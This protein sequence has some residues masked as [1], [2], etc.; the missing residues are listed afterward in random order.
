MFGM[1]LRSKTLKWLSVPNAGLDTPV[2]TTVLERGVRLTNAHVTDIPI[3]EYVLRAVLDH[4]QHAEQWRDAQRRHAWD[5]HQFREVAG[6]TWLIVGLGTIGQA[7]ATRARAFG[8]R[9]VGCRRSP[10]GHESVDLMV[11]PA[12]VLTTL[13]AADV[14]VLSLPSTAETPPL[15]D[16]EFLHAMA[17]G[18]VLVN[19]ARGSLIDEA[20]LLAALD[21]GRP[22]AA[23]LDVMATEPLPDDSPLWV[24][25]RVVLTPH[26]SAGG[27]DRYHRYDDL[28][29]D[30]L[31]RY[32]RGEP[33]RNEVSIP[34]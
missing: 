12:D 19:I 5:R 6:T 4:F 27:F 13:P 3:S 14:V 20:A 1:V 31:G 29:V 28:L 22:A 15:V 25:P 7:V 17:E 10:T 24:H 8:A 18:S 16:A 9:V 34:G 21:R 33:L 26:N 23:L 11:S 2:F 30:N 32:A